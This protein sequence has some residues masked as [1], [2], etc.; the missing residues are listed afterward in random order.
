MILPNGVDTLNIYANPEFREMDKKIKQLHIELKG[1]V[2]DAQNKFPTGKTHYWNACDSGLFLT[3]H[4]NKY[5]N[6]SDQIPD[7]ES[8]GQ[9]DDDCGSFCLRL[10]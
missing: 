1:V 6:D 4:D 2:L 3:R 7:C 5:D 9:S 10:G 8:C